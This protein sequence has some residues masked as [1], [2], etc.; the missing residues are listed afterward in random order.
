MEIALIGLAAAAVLG[1]FILERIVERMLRDIAGDA[2]E[3]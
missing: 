3:R 1:R 2:R